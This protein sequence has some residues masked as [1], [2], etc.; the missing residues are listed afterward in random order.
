MNVQIASDFHIECFDKFKMSNFLIPSSNILVLCGDVGSLYKFNQLIDF[1]KEISSVY[2]KIIYIPGNHEFYT[3]KDIPGVTFGI[4]MKRLYSLEKIIP[5]LIILNRKAVVIKEYCFI[6]CILWSHCN[7]DQS[8]PRYR[9]K[10]HGFNKNKYNKYNKEDIQYI[11]S[12]IKYCKTKN[13]KPIVITHYPPT[14]KLLNERYKDDSFQYLY[15]NDLDHLLKKETV[16]TW[17][18]GHVHWCFD[19]YSVDGTRLI[20]NQ[21]GKEKDKIENYSNKFVINL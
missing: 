13:L 1:F 18:C 12:I 4:L 20:G 7:D 16:H 15:A 3:L 9:V 2:K 21:K 8:F 17:I 19:K 11:E 6:G 5:N 10:I 14:K